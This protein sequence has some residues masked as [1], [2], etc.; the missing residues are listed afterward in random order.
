MKVQMRRIGADQPVVAIKPLNGGG[1]KGLSDP[2]LDSGSTTE[3]SEEPLDKTHS[4]KTRSTAGSREPDELRGSCPVLR[5]PE[6]EIP[7][8]HSPCATQAQ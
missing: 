8:G 5:E 2:V 1:A 6:G 4:R 3:K 7:S